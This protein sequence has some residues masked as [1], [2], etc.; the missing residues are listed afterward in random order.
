[1]IL[2]PRSWSE[3]EPIYTIVNLDLKNKEVNLKRW[4][5][6]GWGSNVRAVFDEVGVLKEMKREETSQDT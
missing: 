6:S 3:K 5:T 4:Q 1:M 2:L